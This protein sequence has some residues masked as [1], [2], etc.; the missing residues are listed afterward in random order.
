MFIFACIR[1]LSGALS[2]VGHQGRAPNRLRFEFFDIIFAKLMA[3]TKD[4]CP[5]WCQGVSVHLDNML[6]HTTMG[7]FVFQQ[8]QRDTIARV[9]SVSYSVHRQ[10]TFAV[11]EWLNTLMTV[12]FQPVPPLGMLSREQVDH[13]K[14]AVV[15]ALHKRL[16]ADS[17]IS[18]LDDDC[19][20]CVV[21][22]SVSS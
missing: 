14:L 19:L 5:E 3:V 9:A 13:R 20:S 1:F 10:F 11:T 4:R 15:M 17:L 22:L 16:G 21:R 12:N 7:I 6:M 2:C 18:V 8:L